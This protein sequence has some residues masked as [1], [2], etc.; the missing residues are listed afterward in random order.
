MPCGCSLELLVLITT[1]CSF[2]TSAGIHFRSKILQLHLRH[3]TSVNPFQTDQT[4]QTFNTE[5][6]Y[7]DNVVTVSN[8]T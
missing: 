7:I 5:A 3:P 4:V 6:Y 8:G 2:G 1:L